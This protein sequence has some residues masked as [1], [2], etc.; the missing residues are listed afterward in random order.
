MHKSLELLH[1]DLLREV[2]VKKCILH[3]HGSDTPTISVKVE[4]C[5]RIVH[6]G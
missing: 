2:T 5:A 3:V 4:A 1:I 6:K